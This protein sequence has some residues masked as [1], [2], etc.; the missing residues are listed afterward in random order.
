MG[1][2]KDIF[3]TEIFD[4]RGIP[5][6]EVTVVTDDGFQAS[7]SSAT[8]TNPLKDGI[9]DLRDINDQR[10]KG[11]GQLQTIHVIDS[12]IKPKL[13]GKDTYNQREIDKLLISLDP[14]PEKRTV[15]GNTLLSTSIAVAKIASMGMGKPLFSY[16]HTIIDGN[17]IKLPTPFFTII[18]GGEHAHFSTDFQEF[19]IVPGS[20]KSY[21]ESLLLGISIHDGVKDIL[22]R[23]NILPFVGEKGGFGPL[24]STNEDAFILISQA[25]EMLNIRLGYDV[26]LGINCFA[27]SFMKEGYYKLKDRSASLHTSELV[28]YYKDLAERYHILYFEDPL[29]DTDLEGWLSLFMAL[30]T[31]AIISGDYY[32][33]S[34]PLK[35]QTALDKKTINGIVIKPS[36]IGTV[37]ESLAVASIAKL[38]GLKIIVSDR[39]GETDDTFLADFAVAIGAD[40][41]SFG[42]PVRGE[43]VAKYNRLLKIEK[44][45]QMEK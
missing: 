28:E 7:A 33:G 17:E 24:L 34:N 37:T 2:I 14:T 22:L 35:I 4:S 42:A 1:K 39:T 9:K 27:N 32:T 31:D 5:A 13:L 8:D 25:L 45:L 6:I 26:Y 20:F 11:Y 38:A 44:E 16:L 3:G 23:E 30:N 43:R 12:V 36:F 10:Y 40:Y 29:A 21:D 41:V 18:D 15:G 19:L